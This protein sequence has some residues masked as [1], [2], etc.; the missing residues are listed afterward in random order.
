[1]ASHMYEHVS[2]CYLYLYVKMTGLAE[3]LTT[4]ITP[5]WFLTCMNTFKSV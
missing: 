5:E 4:H 1:M 2:T 3:R